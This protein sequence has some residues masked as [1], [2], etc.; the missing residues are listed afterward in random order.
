MKRQLSEW[1]PIID[2]FCQRHGVGIKP[3]HNMSSVPEFS[4]RARNT[5]KEYLMSLSF[6]CV[7]GFAL[8]VDA[9]KSLI[10]MSALVERRITVEEAVGLAR[11]EVDFQVG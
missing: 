8:G 2:W 7:Q 9:A 5:I 6:N 4:D 10:L 3:S 11:L 1:Q